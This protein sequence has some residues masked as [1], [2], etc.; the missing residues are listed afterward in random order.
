MP[1]SMGEVFELVHG[2]VSQVLASFEKLKI[3]HQ[4]EIGISVNRQ[5]PMDS[6]KDRQI[7]DAQGLSSDFAAYA[8]EIDSALS[9]SKRATD[10]VIDQALYAKAL[11]LGFAPRF[12]KARFRMIVM[13]HAEI[14]IASHN[15]VFDLASMVAGDRWDFHSKYPLV[16]QNETLEMYADRLVVFLRKHRDARNKRRRK[17]DRDE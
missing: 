12:Y 13:E 6:R 16:S 4:T 7:T 3:N 11:L 14:E 17:R 15:Q 1:S 9:R 10:R 5:S 8:V 2:K